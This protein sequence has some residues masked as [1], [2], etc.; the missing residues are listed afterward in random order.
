MKRYF[1][2]VG[3]AVAVVALVSTGVMAYVQS[4][5]AALESV[6]SVSESSAASSGSMGKTVKSGAEA[7]ESAGGSDSKAPSKRKVYEGSGTR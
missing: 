4:S 3:V 1:V 7:A 6:D 5:G 2:L